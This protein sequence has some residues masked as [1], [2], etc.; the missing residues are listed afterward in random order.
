LCPKPSLG[1]IQFESKS[2]L[3]ERASGTHLNSTESQRVRVKAKTILIAKESFSLATDS[4]QC[5]VVL[6]Q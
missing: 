3:R 2:L 6:H 5:W 1:Q 4:S